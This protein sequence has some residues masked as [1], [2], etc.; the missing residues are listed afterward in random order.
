MLSLYRSGS[1]KQLIDITQGYKTEIL[2]VQEKR[3]VGQSI[4][5]KKECTIY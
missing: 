5:E 2:A 3:W 4:L 1:L